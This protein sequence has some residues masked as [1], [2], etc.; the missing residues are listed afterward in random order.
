MTDPRWRMLPVPFLE[1]N[2]VIMTS[3]L[4]NIIYM[5]ANFLDFIRDLYFS[6]IYRFKPTLRKIRIVPND[7]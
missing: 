6:C 4:L 3:L 2:D 7:S 5:L 1:I